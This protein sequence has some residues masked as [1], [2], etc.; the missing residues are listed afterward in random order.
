MFRRKDHEKMARPGAPSQADRLAS[1]LAREDS[2]V[3]D[4]TIARMERAVLGAWR[5]RASRVE[6]FP[7]RRRPKR[8][9][10][11]GVLAAAAFGATA[12]GAILG[13]FLVEQSDTPALVD[14]GAQFEMQLG[15]GALQRGALAEGQTLESGRYGHIRVDIGHTRVEMEPDARVRFDR[16]SPQHIDL[17]L[18]EGTIAAHFNPEH[19][20]ARQM[21]VETRSARV[22]VVGTRFTVAVDGQG[23]TQVAV[24]EGIVD[25]VP[26]TGATER[27]LAG[28]RTEVLLDGGDSTERAVREALTAQLEALSEAEVTADGSAETLDDEAGAAEQ[29]VDAVAVAQNI[30]Q[31]LEQARRLLRQGRHQ[32]ARLRLR[33]LAAEGSARSGSRAEAMTLMAESFT[34]QGQISDAAEAYQSAA[35]LA[36]TASVG[37]N[38]VFALARLLERYTRDREGAVAAY[39]RY[40]RRAPAGA[41]AG[42]ARRALCALGHSDYCVTPE[43]NLDLP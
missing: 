38:A 5:S 22:V 17:T 19:A 34:A 21:A 43:F 13:L 29:A 41:L 9:L 16:I 32:A 26:R 14:G 35:E 7:V 28:Q 42:Q 3:D 40:L 37:H 27:L 10:S 6:S 18:L 33:R 11:V 39:E 20:S 4:V 25:V 1:A 2:R 30:E 23:N 15:E 24:R 8:L 31:R 12:A 36:P